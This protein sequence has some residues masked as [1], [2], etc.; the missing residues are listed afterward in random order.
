V[1]GPEKSFTDKFKSKTKIQIRL[2]T[3]NYLKRLSS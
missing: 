3:Q 1:C 2:M